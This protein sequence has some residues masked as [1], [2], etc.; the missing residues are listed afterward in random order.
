LVIEGA[1]GV[2]KS[3][4]LKH[5]KLQV[6][7]KQ[8]QFLPEPLERF[9]TF[10]SYNPLELCYIQPQ[11]YAYIT[12]EHILE[13]F[14]SYL[15]EHTTDKYKTYV[16]DR[17]VSSS[18]PFINSFYNMGYLTDFEREKLVDMADHLSSNFKIEKYIFIT[19][20]SAVLYERI[21]ARQRLVE[22][23][24]SRQFI[25]VLCHSYDDYMEEILAEKGSDAVKII[26]FDSPDLVQRAVKF[27]L[28]R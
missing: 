14:N 27:L 19:G 5:I 20:P 4:L 6:I 13:T 16:S 2:G 21:L 22:Q 28:Y 15:L 1:I 26:A 9:C 7:D 24:V 10:K 23:S 12:Q 25:D 18:R 11:K 8:F 3:T 17:C